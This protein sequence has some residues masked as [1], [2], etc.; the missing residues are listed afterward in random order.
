MGGR[1]TFSSYKLNEFGWV[2]PSI[3]VTKPVKLTKA[4]TAFFN[5]WLSQAKQKELSKLRYQGQSIPFEKGEKVTAT[6]LKHL[7][8]AINTRRYGTDLDLMVGKVSN[9]DNHKEHQALNAMQRSL[10]RE[11][12]KFGKSKKSSKRSKKK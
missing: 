10:N 7:Q 9:A 11:Y 2:S 6:K 4:T 3:E 8:Q 5:K 12:E 1:G